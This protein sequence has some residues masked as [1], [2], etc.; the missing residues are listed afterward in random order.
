MRVEKMIKVLMMNTSEI[1]TQGLRIILE[2]ESDLEV[3]EIDNHEANILEQIS[4]FDPDILLVHL[5]NGTND[6]LKRNIHEI[7]RKYE[8]I[9]II[10]IFAAIDK[11]MIKEALSQGV[12]GFLLSHSSGKAL[13]HSI[14][15]VCHHQYVFAD[16]IVVEMID[17]LG[18]ECMNKKDR[19]KHYLTSQGLDLNGRDI[20]ILFL[21][22][23]GYRNIEIASELNLSE[24]T[25]RDYVSKVYK[26][27]QINNRNKVRT[28]LTSIIQQKEV[29]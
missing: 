23:K 24:K 16:E 1:F 14:R 26:K 4:D 11:N 17:F 15:N 19:L 7:R 5:I 9:K 8:N 22:Y 28:Y 18:A 6:I 27:L 3:L 20:D 21:I 25:V 10:Y 29:E 13:V 2:D 12:K